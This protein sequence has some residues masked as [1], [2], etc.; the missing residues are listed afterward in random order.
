M[1]PKGTEVA[2]IYIDS[3]MQVKRNKGFPHGSL[4][5]QSCCL[6]YTDDTESTDPFCL[7]TEPSVGSARSVRKKRIVS[8]F[9]EKTIGSSL[10]TLVEFPFQGTSEKQNR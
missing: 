8:S 2:V 7:F 4:K 10:P 3:G 5:K 6:W 1:L 9:L